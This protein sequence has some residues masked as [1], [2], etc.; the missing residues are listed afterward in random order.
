MLLLMVT[1]ARK[2]EKGAVFLQNF[3]LFATESGSGAVNGNV[4]ACAYYV[5]VIKDQ[6]NL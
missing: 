6:L 2:S 3:E 4:G 5:H 1:K